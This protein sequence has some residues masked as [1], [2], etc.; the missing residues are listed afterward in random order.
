[1][2]KLLLSL[3][4]ICAAPSFAQIV[5]WDN[6]D[7][8]SGNWQ[9]TATVGSKASFKAP[10]F[11][12]AAPQSQ[13][14]GC[15]LSYATADTFHSGSVVGWFSQQKVQTWKHRWLNMMVYSHDGG[16]KL[17]VYVA[18]DHDADTL[19]LTDVDTLR[20]PTVLLTGGWQEVNFD[21]WGGFTDMNAAV[22]NNVWDSIVRSLTFRF[23]T[24]TSYH[25]NDTIRLRVDQIQNSDTT[26]F[27][28]LD[29]HPLT[30][31]PDVLTG[32]TGNT[33]VY[34]QN[35][36]SAPTPIRGASFSG[37]QA[38]RFSLVHLPNIL[39]IGGHDSIVVRYSPTVV[40]HDTATLSF[41]TNAVDHPS[42]SVS[43]YA[44]ADTAI[45]RH[46]NFVIFPLASTGVG[47]SIT[48]WAIIR[49]VGR[50]PLQMMNY[51]SIAGPGKKDYTPL[52]SFHG[53]IMP[54]QTDSIQIRFTPSYP[55]NRPASMKLWYRKTTTTLDSIFV[56][57]LGVGGVAS[58]N[59]TPLQFN[60]SLTMGDSVTYTVYMTNYGSYGARMT[61][62]TV[63]GNDA[64]MFT[65]VRPLYGPLDP[66]WPDSVM[67][68]FRPT[69]LGIKFAYLQLV[70]D[71]PNQPI[72]VV[73]FTVVVGTRQVVA[74]PNA[75]FETDTALIGSTISRSVLCQSIGTL[76]VRIDSIRLRNSDT[77]HSFTITRFPKSVLQ[78]QENDTM[79]IDFTPTVQGAKIDT[80]RIYTNSPSAPITD[81]LLR[82]FGGARLL[83]ASDTTLRDTVTIEKSYVH[84][85]TLRDS[86]NLPIVITNIIIGGAN[87]DQYTLVKP[88]LFP[89]TIQP[90]K[91]D[92][93]CVRVHPTS[94]GNKT[95]QMLIQTDAQNLSNLYVSLNTYGTTVSVQDPFMQ[96]F[97]S[98]ISASPNPFRNATALTIALAPGERVTSMV[99]VDML[100]REVRTLSGASQN[101]SMQ[102]YPAGMYYARVSTN[103]RSMV[104]PLTLNK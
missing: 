32:L 84:C 2:K 29:A 5:V 98:L 19:T 11:S 56:P 43:I 18:D 4:V 35:N 94:E 70:T 96:P 22:G 27:V 57:M 46:D 97:S 41:Q 1:M 73:P 36:G 24:D 66:N 44:T 30:M 100:G 102:E 64:N 17:T 59:T 12:T 78:S 80:I 71:A 61:S 25:A 53:L 90:G 52:S 51:D 72:V 16:V 55:G 31:A 14:G 42:V 23:T 81:V 47:Q 74:N 40:G 95:A 54:G 48:D 67:V 75:V 37:P 63:Q 99:V 83:V 86:G 45:G 87:A 9:Q 21:L 85:M 39:D 6:M 91:T 88:A 89:H 65:I 93:I 92:T 101:L 28:F 103:Q 3:L 49:N 10:V 34:I 38:A 8:C 15:Y 79:S 58:I 13:E 7:A 50:V 62:Q 104:L 77:T 33:P 60:D 26:G 69:S 20:S 76:A 68:R 82:G